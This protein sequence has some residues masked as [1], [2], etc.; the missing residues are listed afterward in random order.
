M[1]RMLD[2]VIWTVVRVPF[3]ALGAM[4]VVADALLDRTVSAPIR[5][6]SCAPRKAPNFRPVMHSARPLHTCRRG[7]IWQ[8]ANAV[9]GRDDSEDEASTRTGI[10]RL[11]SS[12]RSRD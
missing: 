12:P 11:T 9:R 6:T 7:D 1:T 2:V 3:F 8:I 5:G 4:L 10:S